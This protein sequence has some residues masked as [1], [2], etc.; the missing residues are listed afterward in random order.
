[1]ISITLT[2]QWQTTHSSSPQSLL[3]GVRIW[4]SRYLLLLQLSPSKEEE[5]MSMSAGKQPQTNNVTH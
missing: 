1:M 5:R 4:D 3:L 2:R